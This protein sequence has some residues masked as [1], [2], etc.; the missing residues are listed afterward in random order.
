MRKIY[1]AS[2]WRNEQQPNVV[3]SLRLAGH[4]VYDFRNPTDPQGPFGHLSQEIP[5]RGFHWS[6]VSPDWKSWGVS[7]FRNGLKHGIAQTGFEKD[8]RGL[9][10]ADTIVLLLKSGKSAHLEAGWACG[11]RDCATAYFPEGSIEKQVY[12]YIPNE[13][14]PELMYGMMDGIAEYM[15]ELLDYLVM[16]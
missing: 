11:W 8:M 1:V 12:A 7:Q 4:C 5:D 6:E 15:D 10:W 16:R 2:S 9:R 14:E 13:I 3:K